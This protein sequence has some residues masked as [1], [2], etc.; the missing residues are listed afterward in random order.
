MD[1]QNVMIIQQNLLPIGGE[2]TELV[3]YCR[4]QKGFL[5]AMA[6]EVYP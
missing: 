5:I 1:L 6:T 4:V 3:T 2:G